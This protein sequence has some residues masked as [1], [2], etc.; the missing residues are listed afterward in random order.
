MNAKKKKKN[1]DF[2]QLDFTNLLKYDKANDQTNIFYN[3][4]FA[5]FEHIYV[6]FGDFFYSEIRKNNFCFI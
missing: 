3:N 4:K 6:D 5:L 1:V 2:P